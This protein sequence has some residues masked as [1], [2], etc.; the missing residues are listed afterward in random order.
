MKPLPEER[1]GLTFVAAV[2]ASI[3]AVLNGVL[4][5]MINGPIVLSSFPVG[6]VEE[7]TEA[8][9]FWG[10]IVFGVPGLVED[11]LAIFWLIFAVVMLLCALLIYRRPK[12]YRMWSFLITISSLLC[13]PIGGGFY[14]GT[15]LGFVGG[16][17]GLEGRESFKKTFLGRL[18]GGIAFN[19]EVYSEALDDPSILK[20]A[21]MV[22]IFVGA[23]RGLGNGLYV[24]NLNLIKEDAAFASRILLDGQ[25][26]WNSKHVYTPILTSLSLIGISVIEWLTLSLVFYWVGT[27]LMGM[28]SDY[29]KTARVLAYA[30]A[31]V[32]LQ[33]LAP[34]MFSNE[35]MLSF[36][37]PL[38]LYILSRTWIFVGLV[39]A[40]TRLFDI[41]KW[42]AIGMVSLGGMIYWIIDNLLI[43]PTLKVPG[44]VVEL[45]IPPGPNFVLL[46]ISAATILATL[47]GVFSKK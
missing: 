16:I 12:S 11:Y 37:W 45:S 19:S 6:S 23:L 7:V 18:L 20:T 44:I 13:I 30:Y 29:D 41:P 36:T 43:I 31:P 38:W 40:T 5:L 33:L 27:R 35:P 17:T 42:K 24:H 3:L 1:H 28:P 32:G 8:D 22:I 4:I 25:V 14:L 21:A 26:I 34:L 47:L 39:A 15:I 46:S 2:I 9:V 10:R